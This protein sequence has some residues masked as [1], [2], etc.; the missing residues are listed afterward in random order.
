MADLLSDDFDSKQLMLSLDLLFTCHSSP[1]L[2]TDA[3]RSSDVRRLVLDFDSY[4]G[5]DLLSTFHIFLMRTA[6]VLASRFSGVPADCSS[7]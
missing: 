7:R 3:F 4:G 6:E 2:I 1:S 5:T